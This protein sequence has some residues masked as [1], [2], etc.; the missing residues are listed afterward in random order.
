MAGQS[1]SRRLRGAVKFLAGVLAALVLCFSL[2]AASAD[3][4]RALHEPGD[5]SD[6]FC[7]VALFAGQLI[8][9]ADPSPP[10]I[11][12]PDARVERTPCWTPLRASGADHRVAQ[13]R[14]P[15]AGFAA[16]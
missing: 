13:S 7:A 3:L 9:P 10:S 1:Q 12:P 2:C 14:A 16:P 8:A 15:P 5:S 4:H 6:T 11:E